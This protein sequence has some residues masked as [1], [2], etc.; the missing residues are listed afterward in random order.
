MEQ[1]PWEAKS[2][3]ASQEIPHIVWNLKPCYHD[4][5]SPPSVVPVPSQSNAVHAP[6]SDLSKIH[7]NIVLSYSK[8]SL[9]SA[10]PLKPCMHSSASPYMPH[11]THPTWFDYP[12][13]ICWGV[14]IVKL[15]IMELSPV[16]LLPFLPLQ[17]DTFLSTLFSNNL[18]LCCSLNEVD[19]VTRQ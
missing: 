17:S 16:L 6:S 8:W 15:L 2:S 7:Y 5:N 1:S 14:Q 4:H 18:S 12:N 19:C 10:S 3:S 9:F 11:P 13:N